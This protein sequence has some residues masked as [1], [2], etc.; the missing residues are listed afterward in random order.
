MYAFLNQSGIGKNIQNKDNRI[1]Y[2]YTF[3]FWQSTKYFS[4]NEIQTFYFL[5]GMNMTGCFAFCQ[6][7]KF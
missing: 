4:F 1:N 3:Y 6:K 5:F 7:P 2:L